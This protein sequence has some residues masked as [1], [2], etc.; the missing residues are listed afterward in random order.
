[1]IALIMLIMLHLCCTDRVAQ[2]ALHWRADER[3]PFPSLH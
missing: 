1:M 2:S 3:A